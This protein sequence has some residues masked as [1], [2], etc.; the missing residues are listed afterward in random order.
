VGLAQQWD[1][2]N[3]LGM[4]IRHNLEQ[5]IQ[6][7]LPFKKYMLVFIGPKSSKLQIWSRSAVD[8][9]KLVFL[10]SLILFIA[11]RHWTGTCAVDNVEY[12]NRFNHFLQVT[13][14]AVPDPGSGAVL[15]L[16]LDPV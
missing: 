5:Q 14:L 16:D 8:V 13:Y 10:S 9:R 4:R 7:L 1:Q 12:R 3:Q 2:L 11:C 15:T 6:A